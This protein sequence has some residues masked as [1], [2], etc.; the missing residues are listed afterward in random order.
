MVNAKH[1]GLTGPSGV[2]SIRQGI[3]EIINIPKIL[4][5]C[6]RVSIIET[7]KVKLVGMLVW[8]ER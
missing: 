1:P 2:C 5:Y 3:P 6:Y 7:V 4:V 8:L